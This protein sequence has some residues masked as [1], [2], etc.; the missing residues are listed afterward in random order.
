MAYNTG[1]LL[2][3]N[4]RE[5]LSVSGDIICTL[6]SNHDDRIIC[7]PHGKNLISGPLPHTMHKN[8]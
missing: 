7:Y 3:M 6:K 2:S 5:I 1:L 8:R 4:G